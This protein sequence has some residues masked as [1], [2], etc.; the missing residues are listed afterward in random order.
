VKGIDPRYAHV[1]SVVETFGVARSKRV[2]GRAEPSYKSYIMASLYKRPGSPFW[3]IKYK[4]D[5]G[6]QQAHSTGSAMASRARTERLSFCAASRRPGR[7]NLKKA[8]KLRLGISGSSNCWNH[9]TP[10]SR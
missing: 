9:A 1:G 2:A 8:R 4:D 3:Y 7:C 6:G 5:A 10:S